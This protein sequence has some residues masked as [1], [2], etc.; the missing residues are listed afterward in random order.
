MVEATERTLCSSW[1]A[2]PIV[3]FNRSVAVILY[4][5]SCYK[6]RLDVVGSCGADV[7]DF[8]G[9]FDI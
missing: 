4:I 8:F 2:T 3:E 5:S 7:G 1:L 9:A 6:T